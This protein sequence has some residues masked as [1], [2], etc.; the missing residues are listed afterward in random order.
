MSKSECYYVLQDRT[1]QGIGSIDSLPR[2]PVVGDQIQLA[3]RLYYK[4]LAVTFD[5]LIPQKVTL[6]IE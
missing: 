4:V 1:E 2:V 5:I 3:D 6:V